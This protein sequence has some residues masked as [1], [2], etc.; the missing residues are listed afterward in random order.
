MESSSTVQFDDAG[1]NWGFITSLTNQEKGTFI[2]SDSLVLMSNA[3]NKD[4]AYKLM[5]FMLSGSSMTTYHE[6][7]QFAPIG[8]DEEYHDNPAFESV[9]EEDGDYLHSLSPA[10]GNSKISDSLYKNLQ[11]MI[12]G[13][14][15]PDDV[16]NESVSYAETI[17]NE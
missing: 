6:S 14:I 12:M 8:K 1:L 17:L 2:A 10:K 4:L 16:I 5:Q 9:Y 11:L 7:A 3:E 15:S 13:E